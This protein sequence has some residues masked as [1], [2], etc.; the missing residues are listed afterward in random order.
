MK[1]FI[2][3]TL[4]QEIELSK[5]GEL[6]RF[7]LMLQANYD[8]YMMKVK[9]GSCLVARLKSKQGLSVLRK[10]HKRLEQFT[11][12]HC[13]FYLT[14]MNYYAKDKMVEEGIPF[15]LED[16]QVYIPFWGILLAQNERKALSVCREVSFLTQKLLLVALY[17]E[18]DGVTVTRAAQYLNV[19]K[20]S[21]TRCFDEIESLE[22]PVLRKK[23]HIRMI[24]SCGSKR[25]MWKVIEPFMKAPV[26]KEFYLEEDISQ[27]LIKS[28]NSALSEL[29]MLEDKICPTYAVT[30][31]QL[32]NYG[33][34]ERKQVPRGEDPGCVVQELG[35]LIPF[36]DGKVVDPLTVSLIM[37][38]DREEPRVSIA[39]EE[40]LEEYVW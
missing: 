31:Y 36:M 33:I 25:E 4:H 3:R 1:E 38:D 22:I 24:V 40:M 29:S 11:G 19:S 18:W 2:E 26:I 28:G 17:G 35:Y 21:V 8:F 23:G 14:Q 5:Y 20:M 6:D 27:E 10:Q 39:L 15:I 37:R 12:L 7:P 34:K 30:K 16:R 32:K 9:G 13:V